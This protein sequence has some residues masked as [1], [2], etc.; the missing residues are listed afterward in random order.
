MIIFSTGEKGGVGKST[1]ATM[2]LDI[3]RSAGIKV[4]AYD[5]DRVNSTLT[6]MFCQRDEN[7]AR[8]LNQDPWQGVDQIDMSDAEEIAIWSDKIL[9]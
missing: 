7:G 9:T 1:H 2:L 4:A 6:R 8:L 5:C 3:M